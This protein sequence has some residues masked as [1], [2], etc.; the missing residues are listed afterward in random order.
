ML[1]TVYVPLTPFDII[2]SAQRA[3]ASSD[4]DRST[5]RDCL[6]LYRYIN[7]RYVPYIVQYVVQLYVMDLDVT[8]HTTKNNHESTWFLDD[9]IKHSCVFKS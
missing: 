2:C 9:C 7:V 8:R 4:P 1:T 3:G 6:V 5:A